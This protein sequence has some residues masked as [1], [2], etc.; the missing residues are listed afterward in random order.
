M[1]QNAAALRTAI[2][3][4]DVRV[5]LC[6]HFHHQMTGRLGATQV[7]VTPG[8][9]NRIDLTAARGTERAVVGASAT[10]VELDGPHSPL[11][12]VLHARDPRT[13][14]TVYELDADELAGVIAELGPDP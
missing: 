9:V 14:R 3:H 6:G 5:V 7:V 13:G 8:V 2:E 11:S 12:Y 4:S 1:L 10:V